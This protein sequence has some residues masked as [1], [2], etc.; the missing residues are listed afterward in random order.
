[1]AATKIGTSSSSPFP[2]DPTTSNA[3]L[4][5]LIFKSSAKNGTVANKVPCPGDAKAEKSFQDVVRKTEPI[6]PSSNNTKNVA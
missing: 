3:P 1:M 2:V 5:G 4:F 6:V